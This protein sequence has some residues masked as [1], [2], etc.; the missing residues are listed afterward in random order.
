MIQNLPRTR[1]NSHLFFESI[2][3]MINKKNKTNQEGATQTQN[4]NSFSVFELWEEG[5][6]SKY[7]E[8]FLDSRKESFQNGL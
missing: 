8:L 6:R 3:K 7:D 2:K 1:R 5:K 4:F